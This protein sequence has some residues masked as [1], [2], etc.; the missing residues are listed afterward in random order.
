M[1]RKELIE[2]LDEVKSCCDQIYEDAPDHRYDISDE[3]RNARY[4]DAAASFCDGGFEYLRE[5]ATRLSDV[6]YKLENDQEIR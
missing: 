6:I 1:T 2:L 3:L 5:L 4:E